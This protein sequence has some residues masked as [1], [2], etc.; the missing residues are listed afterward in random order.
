MR[1]VERHALLIIL[2][3]SLAFLAGCTISDSRAD[4]E[5]KQLVGP[6]LSDRILIVT[7]KERYGLGETIHYWVVNRTAQTVWLQDVMAGLRVYKYDETS[8]QWEELKVDSWYPMGLAP[9]E[10]QPD[11]S[12]FVSGGFGSVSTY[13]W[14][15]QLRTTGKVRLLIQCSTDPNHLDRVDCSAYKDVEIIMP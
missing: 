6:T 8:S 2:L 7:D 11:A 9:V 13:N 1:Y 5:F 14:S 15:S 12:S 4:D 3:T 10:V